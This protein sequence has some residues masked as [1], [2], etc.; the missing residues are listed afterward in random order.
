MC[1]ISKEINRKVAEED[2][3][4][5]KMLIDTSHRQPNTLLSPICRYFYSIGENYSTLNRITVQWSRYEQAYFINEG[6]H[7]YSTDCCV[8]GQLDGS[9]IVKNQVG[10]I[11]GRYPYMEGYD[12]V[13]V[14]C[15]IP[16][17][18]TYYENEK[19][20]VVS[21]RIRIIKKYS[22]IR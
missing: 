12:F 18:T 7:S 16:K 2:T 21:E 8:T 4:V 20:E 22:I 13:I 9:S 19:G 5:F 11:I 1:W 15:I 6:F 10:D 14:S 3:F 17:G